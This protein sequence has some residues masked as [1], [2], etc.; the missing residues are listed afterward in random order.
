[1]AP[2]ILILSR[3]G[4]GCL[5]LRPFHSE[6]W[7]NRIPEKFWTS[8]CLWHSVNRT[9]LPWPSSLQPSHYTF[10]KKPTRIEKR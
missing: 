5:V 4:Y 2:F 7:E 8:Y 6:L 3:D 10:W 1:M 9:P